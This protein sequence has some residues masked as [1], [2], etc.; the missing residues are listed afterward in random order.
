MIVFGS[1]KKKMINLKKLMSKVCVIKTVAS[2]AHFPIL[3]EKHASM[4]NLLWVTIT[5][6]ASISKTLNCQK[7]C[8][9]QA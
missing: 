4:D 7:Y 3:I 6:L 1:S 8:K 9:I 5:Q 2:K